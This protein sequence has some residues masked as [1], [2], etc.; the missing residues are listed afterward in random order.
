M[1]KKYISLSIVLLL[2]IGTLPAIFGQT[3]EEIENIEIPIFDCYQN[4]NIT[5]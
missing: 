4:E 1:S 5:I 2:A 3:N